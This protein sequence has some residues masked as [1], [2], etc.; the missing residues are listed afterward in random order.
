MKRVPATALLACTLAAAHATG[1][2][3]SGA[4]QHLPMPQPRAAHSATLLADGRVLLAGG[5]GLDGCEHGISGDAIFFEPSSRTFA[6][7]GHLEVPRVGH[8]A[9]SLRDGSVLLIGGWTDDGATASVERYDAASGTFQAHG[10]LLQGRDGFTATALPDGT[11]L[12]AG[13]YRGPMQRL[14]SAEI[15][16]PRIRKSIAVGAMSTPRMSHTATLLSDGRV[17]LAGGSTSRNELLR[18]IEVY[19]PATRR[20]SAAGQLRTARH[21][22]AA[23]RVRDD[24]LFIGGAG[25][26]EYREQFADTELWRAGHESTI[27]GPSMRD[28]RYKFG[29]SVIALRDT[30]ALVAGSGRV[31]ERLRTAGMSFTPIAADLRAELSFSTATRL[32]DGTVLIA[33]GYD[34]RI[35]ISRDAWLLTIGQ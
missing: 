17:L 22:H 21:K 35:R 8:R 28:G 1:S 11:V 4:L 18:S 13:G 32:R 6:A 3:G 2:V 24:V 20:F 12:V 34:P 31:P 5:C 29:D 7:A 16:D 33:G 25:V 23:I 14:A 10:S 15:Y 27:A 26:D 9:V 19:D 30:T